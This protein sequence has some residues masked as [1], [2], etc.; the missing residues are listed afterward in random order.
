MNISPKKKISPLLIE[1]EKNSKYSIFKNRESLHINTIPEFFVYIDKDTWEKFHTH[2]TRVYQNTYNEGQGIF[3][4]K[5]F[6]D[7]HGEF[8][9]ADFYE[10]GE[11]TATHTSVQMSE[12]C[13]ANISEKCNSHDLLMLVWIHTHP[14]MGVFYSGT[15]IRCL[16]T[17][18]YKPF[19]IGIVA[20]IIRR[21]TQGFRVIQ[22]QVTEFSDYSIYDSD[23]ESISFPYRKEQI[24]GAMDIKK[25]SDSTS[26]VINAPKQLFDKIDEIYQEIIR[27]QNLIRQSPRE[28]SAQTAS[29]ILEDFLIN[30][31]KDISDIKDAISEESEKLPEQIN[32]FFNNQ[33]E[34]IEKK[35]NIAGQDIKFE[36]KSLSQQLSL[37][38]SELQEH[39]KFK[40]KKLLI[41]GA[42]LLILIVAFI[43]NFLIK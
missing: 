30:L 38:V 22:N 28:N 32:N 26:P 14:N 42:A 11:G 33:K 41:N 10:E 43:Y 9:I 3:L 12:E 35:I 25:K 21:E 5:Y 4:G 19:Q 1:E 23:E 13:L 36:Q 6:Q 20:D 17:N 7:T 18:F 16:A 37:I 8:V 39:T 40:K 29:G 31:N 15:D 27:T 24:S 2:T 34:F